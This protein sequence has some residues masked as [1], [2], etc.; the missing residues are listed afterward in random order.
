MASLNISRVG[1][2]SGQY[3]WQFKEDYKY[4]LLPAGYGVVLLLGLVLN[5]I[6]LYAMLFCI[7]RWNASTIFMINLTM[8]DTLYIL[9]L[10]LLLRRQ[11]RLALGRGP[12]Q[13]PPLPV[14]RPPLR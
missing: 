9:T 5:G 14:L 12:L 4:I 2:I 6:T 13:N 7:K 1:N 8:C 3:R 11:E 10:H